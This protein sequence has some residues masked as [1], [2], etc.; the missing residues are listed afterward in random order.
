[1]PTRI[2]ASRK[3]RDFFSSVSQMEELVLSMIDRPD[4]HVAAVNAHGRFVLFD[5][6]WPGSEDPVNSA[7]ETLIAF[8]PAT[9]LELAN[10][11]EPLVHVHVD[12]STIRYAWIGSRP[13]T[14]IG[15]DKEIVLCKEPD[16]ASRVVW[17][18]FRLWEQ[19]APLDRWPRESFVDLEPRTRTQDA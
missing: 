19:A 7:Q 14:L 15:T 2:P 3:Q 4:D 16:K 13:A 6:Y 10:T 18:H 17:F 5:K 9:T 8:T 1:M 11:G 12:W